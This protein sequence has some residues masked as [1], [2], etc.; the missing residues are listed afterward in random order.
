MKTIAYSIIFIFLLMGCSQSTEV[1]VENPDVNIVFLHHSTGMNVYKGK[2]DFLSGILPRFEKYTVPSLIEEYNT[3]NGAKIAIRE[4][5]FPKGSPYPWSNYPYDYYNIW[6]KNGGTEP[7]MEEPTL[8]MLTTDYDVIVFKHCFP[9]SNIL[10]NDSVS[11]I[12]SDKKTIGNYTLQYQA[13][14]EKLHSF[15]NTKF[16]IWTGA[17]LTK[18]STTEESAL[19]AREFFDWVVNEWDEPGDNIFVWDFRKLQVGE[20]LYLPDEKAKNA[21]D[22]HLDPDFGE[23]AAHEFTKYLIEVAN[24]NISSNRSE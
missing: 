23:L 18:A 22:S 8:E 11:D 7:F 17:A 3:Q 1:K 21:W 13:L 5:A 19:R 20:G 24:T 6:V 9:V 4:Q 16:I 14:K 10:P 12:N 15:G 2:R